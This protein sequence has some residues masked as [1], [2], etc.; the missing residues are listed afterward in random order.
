MLRQSLCFKA[1]SYFRP[2]E[3]CVKNWVKVGEGGI[4]CQFEKHAM[5][6]F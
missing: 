1:E 5:N 2:F 3:W 4:I 6:Y